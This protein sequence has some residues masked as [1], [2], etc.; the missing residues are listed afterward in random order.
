MIITLSDNGSFNDFLLSI[1]PFVALTTL[2]A[3]QCL[4]VRVSIGS[5]S[6]ASWKHCIHCGDLERD[7]VVVSFTADEISREASVKLRLRED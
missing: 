1:Y 4:I 6:T 7:V 3:S 5:Q 2:G